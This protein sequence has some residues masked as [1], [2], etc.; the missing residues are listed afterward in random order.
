MSITVGAANETTYAARTSIEGEKPG[1]PTLGRALL[2]VSYVEASAK[3]QSISPA[4]KES[5]QAASGA[6]FRIGVWIVED[7]GTPGKIKVTW[8]GSESKGCVLLIVPLEGVDM[9]HPFDVLGTITNAGTVSSVEPASVTTVTA[10]AMQFIMEVN[11]TGSNLKE[12]PSGFTLD[13]N[14]SPALVH[15]EKATAGETGKTKLELTGSSSNTTTLNLAIR[16]K[17]E[18]AANP[19]MAML[20]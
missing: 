12:T 5:T 2:V 18:A 3:V 19:K 11:G 20:L 7:D 4:A 1:T 9:T 17:A 15:R 13:K 16:P 10:A 14:G 8:E 6:S